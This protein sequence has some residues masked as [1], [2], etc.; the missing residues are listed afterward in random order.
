MGGEESDGIEIGTR[1][2]RIGTWT[3]TRSHGSSST[4]SGGDSEC[5]A[6]V[7]N[8]TIKEAVSKN[9]NTS[10]YGWLVRG[11]SIGSEAEIDSSANHMLWTIAVSTRPPFWSKRAK[12]LRY[13]S[14]LQRPRTLPSARIVSL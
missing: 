5:A 12:A 6:G 14:G 11:A 7:N 13:N 9:N 1:S 2:G 4:T 10:T 3:G 8:M